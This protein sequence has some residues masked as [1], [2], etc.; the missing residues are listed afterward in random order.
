MFHIYIFVVQEYSKLH[1]FHR[2]K[3]KVCVPQINAHQEYLGPRGWTKKKQ[4]L[5]LIVTTFSFL[6]KTL[7]LSMLDDLILVVIRFKCFQGIENEITPT[8]CKVHFRV[9]YINV[10]IF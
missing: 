10:H 6:V 4:I 7:K 1:R 5:I 3:G 8:V 9:F 2:V